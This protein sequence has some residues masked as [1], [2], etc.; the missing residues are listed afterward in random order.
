MRKLIFLLLIV[1]LV[2]CKIC[3]RITTNRK[4]NHQYLEQLFSYTSNEDWGKRILLPVRVCNNGGQTQRFEFYFLSNLKNNYYKDMSYDIFKSQILEKIFSRQC[5]IL[6]KPMVK[7]HIPFT[8]LSKHEYKSLNVDSLRLKYFPN[9]RWGNEV[10]DDTLSLPPDLL[11]A[12]VIL[13]DHHYII[14]KSEVGPEYSIVDI[15]ITPQQR[16]LELKKN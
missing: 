16:Y 5:L 8:S 7:D 13:F 14:S 4:I 9:D 12:M 2:N 1:P 3:S 15:S 10:D 11:K 6:P